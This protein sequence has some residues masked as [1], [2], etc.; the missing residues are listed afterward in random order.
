[1]SAAG[2]GLSIG[3]ALPTSGPSAGAFI[4]AGVI[5]VMGTATICLHADQAGQRE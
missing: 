2:D 5:N 1:M 4:N 3:V